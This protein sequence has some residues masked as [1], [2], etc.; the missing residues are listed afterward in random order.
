MPCFQNI[1][2][3]QPG[4]PA[5]PCHRVP[6]PGGVLTQGCGTY[7]FLCVMAAPGTSAPHP[8]LP[9]PLP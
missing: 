5:A 7:G 2:A 9:V 1:P 6:L 8:P 4:I 3:L